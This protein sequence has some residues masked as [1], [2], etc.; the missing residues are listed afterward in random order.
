LCRFK[1]GSDTLNRANPDTNLSSDLAHTAFA[2]EQC[3]A[4]RSAPS[5]SGAH[6]FKALSHGGMLISQK[7]H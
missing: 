4:D 1:F 2:F 5:G 3:R 7:R 6:S